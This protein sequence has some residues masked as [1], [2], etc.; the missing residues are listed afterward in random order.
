MRLQIRGDMR[1]SQLIVPFG[2]GAIVNLPGESVMACSTDL[3]HDNLRQPGNTI[4]DRR[5][6]ERLHV[7]SFVMPPSETEAPTGIPFVRFPEWLFCPRCRRFRPV[8]EWR[9]DWEAARTHGWSVPRCTCSKYDIKLVPARFVI[10]CSQG[11]I[12]DFPWSEW[13]HHDEGV[14]SNPEI[15]LSTG[16][17][18]AGLGGIRVECRT[19]GSAKTMSGTFEREFFRERFPR[20]CTGRKPWARTSEACDA[21]PRTVQRGGSNVYFPQVVSSMH[22]PPYSDEISLAIQ[23][24]PEWQMLREGGVDES[25]R[26]NLLE[27]LASKL[28][29]PL[30]DVERHVGLLLGSSTEDVDR[31]MYRYQEFQAFNVV[32]GE[33]PGAS[34]DFE[35]Q[36]VDGPEY[37]MRGISRVVLAKR[38]R[39]VRALVAFSRLA[40]LDRNELGLGRSEDVEENMEVR[41]MPVTEEENPD[42]LPAVEVRGEGV[43]LAF[44]DEVLAEW[45]SSPAVAR[46][47][48]LI[49]A[50]LRS[51]CER[52]G[53]DVRQ[54]NPQFVLIHTVA[55]LLIRRFS[56]ECGYASAALRERVYCNEDPDR[57]V[58]NGV[59]IYTAA[60]DASG[61]L[62]GLVRQ[63]RPDV[64]PTVLAGALAD[65]RWCSS[66]P[67]CI[68]SRGQGTD[69]LNLGAC[70]A[71]ALLPET[72]CE[73]FN[74]LLDRGLVVGTPENAALGFFADLL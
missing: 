68:E 54:V 49:N 43:F 38:L 41:A 22:I 57:P 23:R 35:I 44:D 50:N 60:G 65:A 5:L 40:P 19:C 1:R 14:C 31:I 63:G 33:E 73:E 9:K 13:V 42:W 67:V 53:I 8:A 74:V 39:E 58:M 59:L 2:V 3:W 11:H 64:L 71:C 25:M 47:V 70:H 48:A 72:S 20:R 18:T 27:S 69:S 6:E 28:A 34:E 55:H 15:Y 29:L 52:R 10:A 32:S 24:R 36:V 7:R 45:A 51:R 37:S 46:R 30:A 12:D 16:A 4:H 17:A 56:F 62:G 21:L 66:D 26:Q 61:T